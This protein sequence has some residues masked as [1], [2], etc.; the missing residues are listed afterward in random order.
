MI[1]STGWEIIFHG[2]IQLVLEAIPFVNW[3][4]QGPVCEKL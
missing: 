3:E 2:L 4:E 1:T